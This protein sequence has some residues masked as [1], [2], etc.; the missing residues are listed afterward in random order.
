M[1]YLVL[2]GRILYSYIFISALP[3]HFAKG[4]ID[5]AAAHGVPFA[6]FAVPFSGIIAFLGGL[7]IVLGYKAKWGGWLIVLFLVPV[8]F[9]MH[10]FW[11][12]KDPMMAQM[13]QI[14]FIKNISMLGAAFLIAHFGSGPLSLDAWLKNRAK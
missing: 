10:N 5:Y 8:T 6:W 12:V 7:S 2:L 3:H 9:T 4:G 13:Q 11:A 14:N 1:K